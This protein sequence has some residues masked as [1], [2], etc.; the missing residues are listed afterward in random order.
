[1]PESPPQQPRPAAGPVP[2]VPA[3]MVTVA[4]AALVLRCSAATVRREIIAGRLPAIR[5]GRRGLYRIPAD[6]LAAFA[7]ATVPAY[8]HLADPRSGAPTRP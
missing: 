7:V 5:L 6:A 2:V 1:M 4:E 8:A 3:Q